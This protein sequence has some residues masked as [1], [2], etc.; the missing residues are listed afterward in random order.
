MSGVSEEFGFGAAVA[1]RLRTAPL[2]LALM[3]AI[4]AM[5]WTIGHWSFAPLWFAAYAAL[6][7]LVAAFS[8]GGPEAIGRRRPLHFALS[9]ANFALAGLPAWHLWTRCGELGVAAAVMFLCGMLV[10]LIVG[11]LGARRL[12]WFSATPLIA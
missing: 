11:C 4:A 2:R 1:L 12:F 5:L 8:L 6:Q 9:T 10:Q 3:G 7:G